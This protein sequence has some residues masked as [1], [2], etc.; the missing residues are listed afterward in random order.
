MLCKSVE[1]RISLH[2]VLQHQ[3]LADAAK[4]DEVKVFSNL[5]E[6]RMRREFL[7]IEN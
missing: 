6:V 7:F 5:E 1:K 4:P 2:D 3:W